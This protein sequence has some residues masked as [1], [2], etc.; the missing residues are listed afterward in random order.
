MA[1]TGQTRVGKLWKKDDG[2]LVMAWEVWEK[3]TGG[4]YSEKKEKLYV[5]YI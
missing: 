1:P 3:F 2:T 5:R 4:K